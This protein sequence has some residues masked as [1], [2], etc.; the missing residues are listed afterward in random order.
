[1]TGKDPQSGLPGPESVPE[2]FDPSPKGIAFGQPRETGS[3]D[4]RDADAVGF[5]ESLTPEQTAAWLGPAWRDERGH[6]EWC[7]GDYVEEVHRYYPCGCGERAA[8]GD[9]PD[10]RRKPE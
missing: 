2:T 10:G 3:V 6:D 5:Y 4:L 9:Y 1:M 7:E 8:S